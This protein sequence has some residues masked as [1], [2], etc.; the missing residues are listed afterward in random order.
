MIVDVYDRVFPKVEADMQ[1]T[2]TNWLIDSVNNL[3]SLNK[4]KLN[5]D[6]DDLRQSIVDNYLYKESEEPKEE[7]DV[8]I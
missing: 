8:A 4:I 5:V 6:E 2:L 7:K 3:R 1:A